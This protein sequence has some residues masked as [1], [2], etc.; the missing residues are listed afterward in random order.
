MGWEQRL[1]EANA[2]DPPSAQSGR[3][4]KYLKDRREYLLEVRKKLSDKENVLPEDIKKEMAHNF[5]KTGR[6]NTKGTTDEELMAWFNYLEQSY[7]KS[8]MQK[9][10][11]NDLQAAGYNTSQA[12]SS[13]SPSSI[14]K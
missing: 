6:F 13:S 3:H 1:A 2:G 10:M 8:F 9:K 12:V 5:V 11:L 4:F 14:G 7:K